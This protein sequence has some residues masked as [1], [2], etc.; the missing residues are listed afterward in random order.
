MKITSWFFGMLSSCL[1]VS[2]L[3]YH[4]QIFAQVKKTNSV[5]ITE[6]STY[7]NPVIH[8]DYSDP[9]AIR[10]GD[11][12]IMTASSFNHIPGLPILTSKDLVN[13]T[14]SG[15]ALKKLIP[16]DYFKTVRHGAG[17]WA[18]SIRFHNNSLYIFYP[19]P[20]FGIYMI[21]AKNYKGPWTDPVLILPGKGLIDPCPFWD[22]N[23]KAY[24]I[25]AYAGSRAGIKSILTVREMNQAGTKVS[26]EGQIVYDGHIIDPTIE[27]PKLYK[28]NQYYYIFAPGG[29]VS[30]GWQT[31]LRSK[32][33]YGPYERKVVMAQGKSDVNGPHQGAWVQT[34]Q[35][36][37]WFLHFQ[38]K[39]A[40]GRI[41]HLQP[42]IWK[43]D[44][45]VIG[46]DEDED[47]IGEPINNVANNNPDF[48]HHGIETFGLP[49]SLD[50]QW[51]A[52]ASLEWSYVHDDQLRLYAHRIV[53]SENNK[54]NL[55]NLLM[56]KFPYTSFEA[57]TKINIDRMNNDE[58]AGMIVFGY[59]YFWLGV[60][61]RND[62]CYL[63][64]VDCKNADKG[65]KEHV[66]ILDTLN[67]MKSQIILKLNITENAKINF[68]YSFD[69]KQYNSNADDFKARQGKWVGAK[70]GLF[71]TGMK[72][73][74]DC[75][76]VD[77]DF[78]EVNY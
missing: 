32:N 37:D 1:L 69:G 75:G 47:G 28:R 30:T 24:L 4:Q 55:P 60:Q 62:T 46:K 77:F 8:K 56:Q 76:A 5:N 74:N 54:Y 53:E 11:T 70:F 3:L 61:K 51:Q 67:S 65:N 20:D 34:V 71:A 36:K 38:D 40:Y 33:I 7:Q 50:W 66:V 63:V 12:Y 15:Y 29:G 44:W 17:V 57:R 22:E 9:D 26:E 14:L 78:F 64:K 68:S 42:M 43:N 27:G 45:P 58:D 52:N 19:D 10:V 6:S 59:D 41:V 21:K 73:T 72:K 23:G 31:V 39:N 13:W 48:I 49:L 2:M 16:V 18:P 25:H 35:G